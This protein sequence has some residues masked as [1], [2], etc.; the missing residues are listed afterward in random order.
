MVAQTMGNDP[1]NAENAHKKNAP[2]NRTAPW[3]IL[4][5]AGRLMQKAHGDA[6]T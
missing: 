3:A 4:L 1:L 5:P 2:R 6:G